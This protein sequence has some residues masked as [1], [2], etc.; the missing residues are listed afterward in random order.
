MT[1]LTVQETQAISEL[2]GMLYN[3]LP[4]STFAPTGIKI[5]FGTVSQSV[6]LGNLWPGGSK[7]PAIEALLEGTLQTKRDR[8][9]DL[10]IRIVQEGIKYR[11][12]NRKPI[13]K[14]EIQQINN[15][16][17][18]LRF[19][20]PELHDPAFISKLPSEKLTQQ[21]NKVEGKSQAINPEILAGIQTRFMKISQLP[22]QDRGYAFERYLHDLFEAYNFNPKPAFRIQG[23]QIDGSI[24]LDHEIYL[25]EAKWQSKA[26]TQADI[27]VLD[28]RVQGHSTIG[29]GVFVT[30]GC[31][32]RDGITAYQRSRPSSI[33][34]IDGQDLYFVIENNLPIDEVLRF[35]IRRLVETGDFH[36]PV[37]RFV[38]QLKQSGRVGS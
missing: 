25:L 30:A 4:G 29:R 1:G 5:D 32:S 34:G 23:E 33:F 24:E 22:P 9:C 38:T 31:F 37:T 27:L 19:K 12:R 35:K 17:A 18:Q 28:G 11:N 14:E 7:R 3:F 21:E 8:F 20:I 36:Y 16:I 6:G 13:S 2:A 26:I 15:L 10:I